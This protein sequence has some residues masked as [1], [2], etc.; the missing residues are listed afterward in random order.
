MD[1]FLNSETKQKN[2]TKQKQKTENPNM[3]VVLKSSE[4]FMAG[5]SL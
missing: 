5:F 3:F 4:L 1:S 2:K